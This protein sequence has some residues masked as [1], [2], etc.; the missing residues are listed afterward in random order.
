MNVLENVY[1]VMEHI[2]NGNTKEK[3][4]KIYEINL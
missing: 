2:Y 3:E 4:I 1:D